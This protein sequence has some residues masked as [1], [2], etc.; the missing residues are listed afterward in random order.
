M[1]K[2]LKRTLSLVLTVLMVTALFTVAPLSVGAAETDAEAVGAEPVIV[3][4]QTVNAEIT[5]G[6]KIAYIKFVP[7]KDMKIIVYSSSNEDTYGYFYDSQKNELDS[8]DDG[9]ENY[10]FKFSYTVTAN[11]T[12]YIGAEFHSR[13]KTGTIPVTLIEDKP[14]TVRF[15]DG[16]TLLG[17][18]PYDEDTFYSYTTLS[19]S[20]Y[21][22]LFLADTDEK[23]FKGYQKS[24]GTICYSKSSDFLSYQWNI[25][26]SDF[27]ADGYLNLY[28]SWAEAYT[29]NFYNGEAFV[30]SAKVESSQ[31]ADYFSVDDSFVLENANG[32][33]FKGY[34]KVG[35]DT[36]CITLSYGGSLYYSSGTLST[37][38]FDANKTL[39]VYAVWEDGYT[40][41]FYNG[42]T[43][44]CDYNTLPHLQI[45][46]SCQT[47]TERCSRD[48]KRM[49]PIH[50]ALAY[51]G[52]CTALALIIQVTPLP[53]MILIPT[54][55]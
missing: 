29:I 3:P 1:Q 40:L 20:D 4:G 2:T 53:Q 24:S 43:F 12:Y 39:N 48:I 7:T 6:G 50:Y 18:I 5:T 31:I 49:V 16:G 15:Y 11:T 17:S 46:L 21:P 52:A 26:T 38:D 36:P 19:D 27:D 8:N 51:S 44:L 42:E 34:K 45:R 23:I 13:K 32:K 25:S 30:G 37:E 41:S 33:V 14:K 10:N 28:S 22:A 47:A 54:E 9:G 35:A 55:H